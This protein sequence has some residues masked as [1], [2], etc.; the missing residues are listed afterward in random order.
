MS[1]ASFFWNIDTAQ[2]SAI[3]IIATARAFQPFTEFSLPPTMYSLLSVNA[4]LLIEIS[5]RASAISFLSPIALDILLIKAYNGIVIAAY[6]F[7]MTV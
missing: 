5:C 3:F 6:A 1:R 2:A 4:S 7:I